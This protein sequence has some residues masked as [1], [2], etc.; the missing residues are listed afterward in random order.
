[1]AYAS[2]LLMRKPNPHLDGIGGGLWGHSQSSEGRSLHENNC[3]VP[4]K[5]PREDMF[6]W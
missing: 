3:S 2:K 1:M 5:V 4:V 6:Q